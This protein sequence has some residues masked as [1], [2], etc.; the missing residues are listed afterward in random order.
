V[1]ALL[2]IRQRRL[3]QEDGTAQVHV[4]R[5]GHRLGGHLA[6]GLC[7]RIRGV[8]DY[9]IN[10]AELVHRLLHEGFQG[11]DVAEVGGYADRLAAEFA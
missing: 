4:V 2:E 10:A 1:R 3:D 8:V 5:L 11:V 6:E 7:Q 9:H